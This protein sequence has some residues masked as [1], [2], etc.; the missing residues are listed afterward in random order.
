MLSNH[1]KC[2]TGGIIAQ[3]LPEVDNY[4]EVLSHERWSQ[5][6]AGILWW[7]RFR[8]T[9]NILESRKENI[10]KLTETGYMVDHGWSHSEQ[11]YLSPPRFLWT[12]GVLA[13]I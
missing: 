7:E 6:G 1:Q 9:R 13:S 12:I 2:T 5:A 10:Y 11:L 3:L 8:D 4:F